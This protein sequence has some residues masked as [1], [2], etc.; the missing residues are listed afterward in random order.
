MW[1]GNHA[2]IANLHAMGPLTLNKER[3]H[4]IFTLRIHF[5]N[6]HFLHCILTCLVSLYSAR[7][8]GSC[9]VYPK[10]IHSFSVT[11]VIHNLV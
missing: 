1:K 11:Q 9:G 3:S 4:S 8:G 6:F 2:V 7:R 10:R 5:N